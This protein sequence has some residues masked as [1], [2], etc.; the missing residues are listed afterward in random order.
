MTKVR[1]VC[2]TRASREEFFTKTALGRSAFIFRSPFI[3]LTLFP[4]NKTGL[5]ALYNR[6]LRAAQ[7]DPAVLIF[8]H[9]DVHLCDFCWPI[10]V[11]DGLNAFDIVGVVGN[12]RRVPAQPHWLYLDDKFTKDEFS[13]LSGIVAQGTGFPP[14]SL[15]IYGQPGKEVK[16]LDGLILAARSEVLLTNKLEFDEAFDFHFYDM[17]FCRQAE[18]RGLRIGTWPLSLIHESDGDFRSPTWRLGYEKYLQ[19]WK[20]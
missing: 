5:P 19:K 9:D 16:L 20:S 4:D 7:S 8:V 2:A 14:N 1:L 15:Y 12:V 11:L 17:D 13:N 6:V 10:H 3:E 18:A